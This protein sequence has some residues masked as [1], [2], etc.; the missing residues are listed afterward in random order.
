MR[1]QVF[2]RQTLVDYGNPELLG[3]AIQGVCMALGHDGV[4]AGTIEV[5]VRPGGPE[6]TDLQGVP[7]YLA[8]DP[9][10][11]IIYAEGETES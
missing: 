11:V 10:M 6:R 7:T 4:N 3:R 2:G 5:S 1:W 9:D 8:A